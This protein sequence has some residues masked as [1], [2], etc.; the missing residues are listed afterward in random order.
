MAQFFAKDRATW[1]AW[2]EANHATAPEVHLVFHR[3]GTGTAGVAYAEAVE[4]AL[5]FGWIDGIVHKVDDTRFTYR[6]TPRRKGSAW[7]ESNKE[8][9]ARLDAAGKLRPAG[10]RA[11]D[12]AK[13]TGAWDKPA[14][15]VMPTA[16]PPELAAAF[17]TNKK[18]KAA[19]AKQAPGQQAAW[20]KWVHQAK[21]AATRE[22]RAKEAVARLANEDPH[23]W[24]LGRIAEKKKAAAKAAKRAR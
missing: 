17:A 11:I 14:K 1:T 19:Y 20:Q 24:L 18:A 3:K 6:F 21:Q 5:C 16:M 13:D 8:R 12:E 15:A 23:P 9:I 4:E 22:R 10:Q 7:S 2:L